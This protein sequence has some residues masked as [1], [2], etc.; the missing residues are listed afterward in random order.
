MK[1]VLFIDDEKE[2]HP[3]IQSFFPKDQFRLICASDGSEGMQKCR[4]E[5]FDLVIVDFRMPKIDG[6]KFYDQLQDLQETRK[7]VMPPVIFVSG[8]ID[9]LKAKDVK[10]TKCEFLN[11]PFSK[12]ELFQ[13][14]QKLSSE[15]A[16][17]AVK[18]EAKISLN[19]GEKLFSEGDIAGC[20]YY[21][22]SGVMEAQ[23]ISENGSMTSAGKIGPGELVGEMALF[24]SDKHLMT[25]VAIERTELVPIPTE[26]VRAIVN[27]QPKWIKLMIENLSRRLKESLQR[28]A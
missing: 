8:H 24:N 23:M 27:S 28:I 16:K 1:K 10:W 22:V 11:K 13:K 20:I 14:I 15:K 6:A 17:P 4:N 21:V 3:V 5:E 12:E 7:G 2:L 26:K 25:M 9:E 18:A 19:P